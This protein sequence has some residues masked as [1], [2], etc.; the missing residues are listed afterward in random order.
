MTK[1]FV[2]LRGDLSNVI[3]DEKKTRLTLN[4]H[5]EKKIQTIFKCD[6]VWSTEDSSEF[7]ANSCKPVIDTALDGYNGII[8]C[9]GYSSSGKTY[10]LF[11]DESGNNG[12]LQHMATDFFHNPDFII[13]FSCFEIYREKLR[14][15]INPGNVASFIDST[16]LCNNSFI[17]IKSV[18]S[19][20]DVVRHCRKNRITTSTNSNP[21]SSRSH[22]IVNIQIITL[23]TVA[24][25]FIVDL[26]GCERYVD[27]NNQQTT[28]HS[29][30]MRFTQRANEK[31]ISGDIHSTSDS[32]LINTSILAINKVVY[33]ISENQAFINYRDSKITM[34]L[35][36]GFEGR[37]NLV[38][39]LCCNLDKQA[40]VVTTLRFGSR[41]SAIPNIVKK[42]ELNDKKAI[43]LGNSSNRVV[44]G[45]E[46]EN[47]KNNYTYVDNMLIQSLMEKIE[48]IENEVS[49]LMKTNRLYEDESD[50]ESVDY[51]PRDSQYTVVSNAKFP[52]VYINKID[53]EQKKESKD[54]II[55]WS[56]EETEKISL[57]ENFFEKIHQSNNAP[58]KTIEEDKLSSTVDFYGNC[59]G[60]N[61]VDVNCTDTNEVDAH[62]I[63]TDEVD[64]HRI[65]TNEVDANCT[66]TNEVDA[67]CET[68]EEAVREKKVVKI[69][70][71]KKSQWCC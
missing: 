14:D 52:N 58:S 7:Y 51:N 2:K 55:N 60:T 65:G 57:V 22:C 56:V 27:A 70:K 63:G 39:I 31:S 5:G 67:N 28:E 43:Y 37:C 6:G 8:M 21:V 11:G 59:T 16:G 26:A 9:Y 68:S 40:E 33:S 17:T 44:D 4:E 49:Q 69:S 12:V 13:K 62:C 3:V 20:L 29:K 71:K 34:A 48:K 25:L 30:S 66:G 42:R 19:F 54:P 1:V 61:E 36:P 47:S 53:S 38:I 64:A 45:K 50:Y 10:T 46:V 15:L 23:S 35:K 41:C 18:D 32:R 24:D